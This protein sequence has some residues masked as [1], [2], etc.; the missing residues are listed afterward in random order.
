MDLHSHICSEIAVKIY[1]AARPDDVS[2]QFMFETGGFREK[3]CE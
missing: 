2:R 3:G 1:E